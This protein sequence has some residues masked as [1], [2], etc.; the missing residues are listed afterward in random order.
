MKI[1]NWL[2]HNKFIVL[3]ILTG[4]ILR[5][6][7]VDFQS[8]W[9]DEIFSLN[10]ASPDKSF[11]QIFNYIKTYDPHPPLYYFCLN[12]LFKIFGYST[13]VMRF[14]SAFLGV[15]GLISIFFLAKEMMNKK[16]AIV[17]VLLTSFNYFHI[18]YS[19]EARMYSMLFL[20]TCVA[21]LFLIRFIKNPSQKTALFYCASS[22]LMIYT[23][24]FALFVW[25]Y[26]IIS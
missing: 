9:V 22:L 6:Y 13:F 19:Q 2:K 4:S 1:V 15:L 10:N 8:V 24:F 20:T 7:K 26:Q 12:V 5:F 16:V 11:G 21:Y 3:L 18:Y 14:F 23:H 17:A 25:I